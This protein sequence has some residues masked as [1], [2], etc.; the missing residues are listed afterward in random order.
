MKFQMVE[1]MRKWRIVFNGTALKTNADGQTSEVHL[2]INM[3]WAAFSR[4]FEFKREF[5]RKLLASGMARE[6]WRGRK[7]WSSMR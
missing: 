6:L 5:S 1:A 2:R 7:E 4:P 3:I